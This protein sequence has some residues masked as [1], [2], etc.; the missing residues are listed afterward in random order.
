MCLLIY[1]YAMAGFALFGANDP[2]NFGQIGQAC[3][4]LFQCTTFAEWGCDF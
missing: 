2:G 4:S 1:L 3:L